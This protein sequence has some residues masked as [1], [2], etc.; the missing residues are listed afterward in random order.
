[1]HHAGHSLDKAAGGVITELG[2]VGGS[3]GLVAIDRDGN[4]AA[5][6]NCSGM[7]RGFAREDGILHTAIYDEPYRAQ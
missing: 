2:A 7:Y 4:I 6:F 3:G 5:P 1:M